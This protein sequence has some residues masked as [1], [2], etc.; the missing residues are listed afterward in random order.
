[1]KKRIIA[2]VIGGLV[3]ASQPLLDFL[4]KWEGGSEGMTVYADEL[5]NGR[6]TTCHGLTKYVTDEPVIVGEYWSKEKCDRVM[7]IAVIKVQT[8]LVDC[9][10]FLPPQSVFDGLSSLA[11]NVGYVKACNSQSAKYAKQGEYKKACDLLA[12][13]FSGKP[14]WSYASGQFIQGLYNRRQDNRDNLCLSGQYK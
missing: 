11:W 4:S 13:T 6:P 10:G 12:T 14:N 5:A 9:I 1:M 8:N 3:L 7:S 2:G